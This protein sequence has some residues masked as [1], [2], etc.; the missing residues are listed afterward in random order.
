MLLIIYILIIIIIIYLYSHQLEYRFVRLKVKFNILPNINS[1]INNLETFDECMKEVNMFYWLGEGTA[2]GA[3]REG[4]IIDNDDDVD[5]GIYYHDRDKFI[6]KA[7]P[8][9]KKKGFKIVKPINE[10]TLYRKGSSLDIDFTGRGKPCRAYHWPTK[11]DYH[12]D[13]I[14]PFRYGYINNK[15]Y[16]VPS[17][18]YIEKL[19]G[20]R[21]YIK[22][23]IKPKNIN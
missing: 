9:L 17:Q 14:K 13:T 12:M 5:V 19:Y 7:M 1:L 15:Q 23:K 2:L 21:W 3:I 6:S 22:Q 16:I 11:C 18:K 8:L 10:L 20:K 4:N